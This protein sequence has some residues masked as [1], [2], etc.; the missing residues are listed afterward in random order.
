MPVLCAATAGGPQLRPVCPVSTHAFQFVS[1]H[2]LRF[3]VWSLVRNPALDDRRA[4]DSEVELPEE[5]L[6]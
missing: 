3:L 6:Q 4:L 5:R 1:T 2:P